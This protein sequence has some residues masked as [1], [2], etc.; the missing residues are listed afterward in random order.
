MHRSFIF[1][2][3]IVKSKELEDMP[4]N[5]N[6]L[7]R[8]QALDRCFRNSGRRYY[9]NDL[10]NEV[11]SALLTE[12]HLS[13]GIQMRQLR[14]D[15]KHMRSE[16]GYSAPI[17]SLVG[18]GRKEYYFYSDPTFSISNTAVNDTELSQ[19]TAALSLFH[20]FDG[21]P[22]FEWI[23]EIGRKLEDTF[24]I[25]SE[26]K[27]MFFDDNAYYEGR[28]NI[29]PFFNAILNKRV[30]KVDY[31]PFTE[32]LQTFVFHPQ[33]LRQYNKRWF[34]FGINPAA[35][36][37]TWNL[38]LDRV[39]SVN[40]ID[41]LYKESNI[42]WNEYFSEIVGVSKGLVT[43]EE[44]E[45]HLLFSERQIP[46]IRTK[47]IHES[48]KVEDP[49]RPLLVKLKLVP[50][51]E[52]LQIILSFGAD[53]EVIKPESLRTKISYILNAASLKYK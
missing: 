3:N 23:S 33:I 48:Q 21:N 45:I 12:N 30:L 44:Q 10:L 49:N 6:A 29:T 11:C 2:I 14:K 17:S 36:T 52:F 1:A 38:A 13:T 42:D 51:F 4:T 7:L 8:Y 41:Q 28:K 18:D 27:V 34:V 31:K 43:T 50:N 5:K 24:S 35:N 25:R 40:E 39:L 16:D 22:G 20:R 32:P 37:D 26:K 9:I 19:I 46:Y 53:V 47:P 15:I